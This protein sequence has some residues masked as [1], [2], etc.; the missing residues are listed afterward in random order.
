MSEHF[1]GKFEVA[2]KYRLESKSKCLTILKLMTHEVMLQDNL[3]SD[4]YFDT[5]EQ[6]L[7]A[8]NKSLC[9]REIERSGIKLWIVKG[10]QADC[11]EPTNITDTNKEKSIIK[12]IDY[13]IL[14]AIKKTRSLYFVGKFHITFDK[15]DGLGEFAIMTDDNKLLD[16]YRSELIILENI[17]ICSGQLMS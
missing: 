12:T 4:C 6:H 15:L 3:E 13:H 14:L 7:F 17:I 11:C 8:E 10:H 2:L 1:E 9:I 5:A 16:G